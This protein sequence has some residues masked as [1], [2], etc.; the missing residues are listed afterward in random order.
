M[1]VDLSQ[2][3]Q[4][5]FEESIEGLE[6]MEAGLLELNPAAVDDETVNAIFRRSFHR[7]GSATF[8]FTDVSEFTRAGNLARS[9]RDGSRSISQDEIDLFLQ[10]VDCLR[11]M[12]TALQNDTDFDR[13]EAKLLLARFEAILGGTVAS[14]TEAGS[15]AASAAGWRI[16]FRPEPQILTT[17]NEPLRRFWQ[18]AEMG[19]LQ[20]KTDHSGLPGFGVMQVESCYLSWDLTL[21]AEDVTQ[22]QVAEV[23]EWVE[24]DAEIIIAPLEAS[25]DDAAPETEVAAEDSTEATAVEPETNAEAEQEPEAPAAQIA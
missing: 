8:G 22:E 20:V 16:Q 24:D 13:K 12:L 23:F 19:E 11:G 25:A 5:F 9:V 14:S 21:R 4:V 7:G 3:H 18:L 1:S 17:G 15:A 2:F 6:V 10:S